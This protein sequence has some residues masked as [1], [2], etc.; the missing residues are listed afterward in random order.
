MRPQIS[1]A[2]REH[3]Q[4]M[5]ARVALR[6]LRPI[7]SRV[8]VTDVI[9]RVAYEMG[10]RRA[11][12]ISADRSAGLFRARAAVCWL[13]RQLTQTSLPRIGA[14]LGGRH[15]TSV[16]AACRRAADMRERDPAFRQLTDRLVQHFRDI[17]E[18]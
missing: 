12:L 9:G 11:D 17:Q 8:R 13:A 7:G 5:V 3:I 15:H 2:E 16:L 10:V 4:Q 1:P 18:D 14:H 6:S